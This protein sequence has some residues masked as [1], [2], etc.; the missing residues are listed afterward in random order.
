M[1]RVRRLGKSFPGILDF[2]DEIS[3]IS[4]A[5]SHWEYTEASKRWVYRPKNFVALEVHAEHITFY[6]YGMPDELGSM[7]G[8]TLVHDRGSYSRCRISS[9]EQVD[10]LKHYLKKAHDL[11][12]ERVDR[13]GLL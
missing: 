11:R 13:S 10:A 1:N 2:I 3:Q 9:P 5:E 6:F 8:L 12:F 7:P 4:Q